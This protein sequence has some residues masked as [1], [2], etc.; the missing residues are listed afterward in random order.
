MYIHVILLE[1]VECSF[2]MGVS[3][4]ENRNHYALEWLLQLF[5]VVS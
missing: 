3:C 4:Y 1:G 5:F 2:A